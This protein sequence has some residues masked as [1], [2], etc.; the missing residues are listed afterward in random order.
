VT[1]ARVQ[2]APPPWAVVD[3]SANKLARQVRASQEA[4][5]RAGGGVVVLMHLDGGSAERLHQQYARDIGAASESQPQQRAAALRDLGTG[6]SILVD[7]GLRDLRLLT[8][9]HRPIVGVEAYGLQIV[10]FV[11]L[12]DPKEP[13][14]NQGAE[15]R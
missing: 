13:V 10:E 2:A 7:L 5:V 14:V 8:T 11:P 15:P 3:P 1:T 9:S 12:L 4:I 6:C